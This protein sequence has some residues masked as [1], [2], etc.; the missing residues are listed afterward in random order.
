MTVGTICT[1][2]DRDLVVKVAAGDAYPHTRKV[3]D[4]M[5]TGPLVAREGDDIGK[6]LHRMRGLGVRRVPVI[7]AK[8]MVVGVLSLDD[9]VDHLVR[10]MTDVAGS[11]RGQQRV[12][13]R[14][15]A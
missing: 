13:R 12:E 8:G 9:V 14:P 1:I 15:N 6:T 4:V 11:M 5:T 7:D 2:T 3:G 10:Q